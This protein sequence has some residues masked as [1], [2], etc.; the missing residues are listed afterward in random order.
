MSS[1]VVKDRGAARRLFLRWLPGLTITLLAFW[2]LSRMID[3]K[4]FASSLA[5]IPAG[6]LLLNIAIY[7][8]SLV[9][10]ALAWQFLL[11]RKVTPAQAV[12]TIS[13]GYLFNNFLPFRLGDLARGFLMGRKSGL[14][15]FHVLSSIMVERSFDLAIAAG[16]LL[17]ALP[18]A[19]GLDQARPVA[20][21][22]LVV[23]AVGLFLLYLA[24]KKREWVERQFALLGGRWRWF[25]RWVAP[26]IASLLDGLSALTRFE[27]FAGG[28][29][30]LLSS[31]LLA[32]LRDW[33]LIRTFVPDAP[34][35]WAALS[36]SAAN[37]LGAVPS[38]MGALGTYELG[39]TGALTLVGMPGE[40]ALAYILVVH[41]THLVFSTL[42]GVYGLSQE[43]QTVASLYAEIR[44]SG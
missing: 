42:I 39:G 38:V 36:I 10:R 41:I 9:L 37:I 32:M 13:E 30:L 17:A 19:L 6:M 5:R 23:V 3:W 27:F 33:A 11:Q 44:R 35:W 12:L 26:Q 2:L 25:Q 43:G 21:A 4:T 20:I 31:W 16:L 28:L 34:L 40:A 22:L 24:A 8:V 14:G 7:L 15:M 18:L 1:L 29:V